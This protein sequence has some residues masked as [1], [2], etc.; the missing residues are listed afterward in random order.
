MGVPKR[1]TMRQIEPPSQLTP[2]QRRREIAGIL[3]TGV[4]RLRQ[5]RREIGEAA[6]ESSKTAREPAT[7]C[8]EV[9]GE[10]VLSVHTG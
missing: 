5:R 4:A 9:S 2:D 7:A 8:L 6:A 10:T 3:A 1:T